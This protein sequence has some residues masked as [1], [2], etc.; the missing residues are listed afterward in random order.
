MTS[1]KIDVDQASI[2][3][4][5]ES[6]GMM[7][8]HLA[9]HMATAVNRTAKSVSVE[10]AKELGKVINFSL[11]SSV[12][13]F[14]TKRP[15]KAATLKKA[16]IMKQKADANAP[17]AVIKL[18][19]GTPFPIRWHSAQEY[20]KSR[21]GKRIRSGV[22]YKPKMGGGWTTVLDG[23]MVKQYGGN[24][25]KREPE[26][27]T[28]LRKIKSKA[29]GDY[30]EEANIPKRA[31]AKAAKRLPIEIRR[32]LRDVTLAASGKIKLRASPQLGE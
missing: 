29:P 9:R 6:L 5:R 32:R 24:F 8:S 1:I 26:G 15:T 7:H 10:A 18:W 11:H 17:Q 25:Y 3:A 13:P 14:T 27:G 30:F 22:R 28:R 21:K 16:V 19:G 2:R 31:A 23:F 12:K 20:S 4:L